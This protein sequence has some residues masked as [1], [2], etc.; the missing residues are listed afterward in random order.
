L[1]KAAGKRGGLFNAMSGERR[2]AINEYFNL[3]KERKK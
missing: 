3:R 2:A 1:K